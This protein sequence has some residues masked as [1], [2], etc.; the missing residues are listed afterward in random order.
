MEFFEHGDLAKRMANY[1]TFPEIEAALIT[2]QVAQAL[3]YMHEKRFIHRDIKPQVGSVADYSVIKDVNS[4]YV[5]YS[6]LPSRSLLACQGGGL[7]N[8]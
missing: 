7:W 4:C 1:G 3:Q 5:E 8:C 2:A 6:G